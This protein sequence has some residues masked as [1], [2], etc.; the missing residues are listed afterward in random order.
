M[1]DEARIGRVLG[2]ALMQ[3]SVYVEAASIRRWADGCVRARVPQLEADAADERSATV[4][5]R[6]PVAV[7]GDD[8]V[9]YVCVMEPLD[10]A[11]AAPAAVA[12]PA[13]APAS[14]EAAEGEAAE[15][16]LH[17]GN[18]PWLAIRSYEK[19]LP[20]WLSI[21]II[22]VCLT[23]SALFS[24]LNLGLMSMDQTDLKIVANTGSEQERRYAQAIMPVRKMG[25]YLLCS[26]LLGNVL[27]NSTFTILLD[28]LTSGLVAIVGS[29]L[30]IVVF[31]EISPQAVCS[32][33]GLAVGAKT[34]YITKMVMLITFPLSYPISKLLDRLLGV[35]LGNV[36]NRERLKELVKPRD[37][38]QLYYKLIRQRADYKLIRRT[39]L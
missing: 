4:Q 13:P 38:E 2:R 10:E 31:G 23:F 14:G 29:T 25:N 12:A 15:R 28:D 8:G 39:E 24:G 5:L 9:F 19:L 22:V 11:Q 18:A 21:T 17:Q 20:T 1:C 37:A 7:D 30:A 33:H 36:Y 35:E 34:I 32:R 26:I 6:V 16:W 27:V 3:E